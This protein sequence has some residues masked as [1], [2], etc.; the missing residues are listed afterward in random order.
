[1]IIIFCSDP[2]PNNPAIE[3]LGQSLQKADAPFLHINPHNL[4]GNLSLVYRTG[5]KPHLLLDDKM[6]EPS[7]FYLLNQWRTDA[8]IRFRVQQKYP[9]LYRSRLLQ[10][11]QDVRFCFEKVRWIPGKLEAI[12]RGESKP[13]VFAAA[14]NIGLKVPGYTIDSMFAPGDVGE[15]SYQKGLGYPFIISINTE[16][17]KEVAITSTNRILD[18]KL[19]VH[20]G[21]FWQWQEP[22]ESIAQIRSFVCRS[23]VWSAIWERSEK[24]DLRLSSQVQKEEIVWKDYSLPADISLKVQILLAQLGLS[25]ASPEFL[26]TKSGDLILI[27]LNPCGD[28][29]GFFDDNTHEA[30]AD[31]IAH[32]IVAG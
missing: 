32:S 27:D 17:E 20:D 9:A 24:V 12:E 10:F 28:W 5:N 15:I 8:A 11:L 6:I 2:F 16:A 1:M 13:M 29:Y 26:L 19:F 3:L 23:K 30:I 22:I 31:H 14:N 4:E 7:A 25:G 21:M 18:K